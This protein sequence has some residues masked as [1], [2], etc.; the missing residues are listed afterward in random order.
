MRNRLADE[1]VALE[2]SGADFKAIIGKVAGK[3]GK[4]AY[5][6]GDTESGII[7]CGQAVGLVTGVKSVQELIQGIISEARVARDRIDALMT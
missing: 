3:K 4:E 7:P 2:D 5:E 6:T 1:S